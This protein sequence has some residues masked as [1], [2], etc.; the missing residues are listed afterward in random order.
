MS[1]TPHA[2]MTGNDCAR[3]AAALGLR[4]SVRRL[5]AVLDDPTIWLEF[6]RN[7]S[8]ATRERGIDGVRSACFDVASDLD[9]VGA[10][11][12]AREA[13]VIAHADWNFQS[14]AAER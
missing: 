7:L 10:P 1:A 14:T 8:A 9:D 12:L 2:A 5:S 4:A 11:S 13:R 6:T 3:L